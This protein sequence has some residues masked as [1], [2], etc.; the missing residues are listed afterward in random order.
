MTKKNKKQ[1]SPMQYSLLDGNQTA[2]SSSKLHQLYPDLNGKRTEAILANIIT[3]SLCKGIGFHSICELF[4]TGLIDELWEAPKDE[5]RAMFNQLSLAKRVSYSEVAEQRKLVYPQTNKILEDLKAYN[6]SFVLIGSA[7]YPPSLLKLSTPPRWLFVRGKV[8][9]LHANAIVALVGTR[10]ATTAGLRLA[11]QC[12]GELA[13]R[14]V[15]VLSGLAKGIDE[16]SHQGAVAF[17]GQSI[18]ILG[19]GL[20]TQNVIHST[21]LAEK[22]IDCEGAVASEYLPFDIPSKSGFLRRNEL[23]AALSN[24]V[25]P[26]ECPRLESGTGAT[27]RRAL[28]IKTP[29][30]G[31]YSESD[32][33][34]SLAATK[35][36]LEKLGL[37]VFKVKSENSKD[38]WEML[39]REMPEHEWSIDLK[40]NQERFFKGLISK[41]LTI[42]KELGIDNDAIDRFSRE[43]KEKIAD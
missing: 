12:A 39:Q 33:N 36:N 31:I 41:V 28:S 16:Y 7:E 17:Y 38:F 3:L 26:V 9:C 5:H 18:A 30:I 19:Y 37:Q 8:A 43:L 23:Q 15:V 11:F 21:S 42:K 10:S 29:V 2:S 22:I 25:I 14:D 4:D 40:L 27:I 13:K 6:I 20:L 35:R 1:S 32:F 34:E 24:V